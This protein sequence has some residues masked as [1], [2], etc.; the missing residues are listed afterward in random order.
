L[1]K[2]SQ[3]YQAITQLLPI[4]AVGPDGKKRPIQAF[5][6]VGDPRL[7]IVRGL[8]A[9]ELYLTLFLKSRRGCDLLTPEL[10]TSLHKLFETEDEQQRAGIVRRVAQEEI[11]GT[12]GMYL[13]VIRSFDV[14][15]HPET[16][17]MRVS[18]WS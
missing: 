12:F 17:T 4:D 2:M 14:T 9:F 8:R 7:G 11:P 5:Q 6:K 3:V 10:G 13:E 15:V 18:P 1:K 16:R